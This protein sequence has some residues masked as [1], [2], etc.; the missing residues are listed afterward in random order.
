MTIWATAKCN[1]QCNAQVQRPSETASATPKCNSQCNAQVQRPSATAKCNSQCNG[2]VQRPSATAKCNGQ[3]ATTR[4]NS[5]HGLR[6]VDRF[7]QLLV[8]YPL[9]GVLVEKPDQH[10]ELLL[11][12]PQPVRQQP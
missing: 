4:D 9:V 8:V 1:S 6:P 3:V 7:V 10:A 2:Q 5:G 12:Q 11:R